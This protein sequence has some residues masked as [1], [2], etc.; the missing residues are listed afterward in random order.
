MKKWKIGF[1]A[2]IFLLLGSV[3]V[4]IPNII[5]L[6][7]SIAIK[8]ARPA[9]FRTLPDK[10]QLI[11]WWPGEIN[12]DSIH[13]NN[14]YYRINS[15]NLSLLTIS[16]KGENADMAS[17]LVLIEILNDSTQMEWIGSM[18][19]SYNP[20]KRVN[21]YLKAKQIGRDMNTILQKMKP[22]F[23][24]TKNIYGFEIKEELVADSL[25]IATSASCKGFPTTQFIYSLIDKLSNYA[26]TNSSME[27]GYPMLNVTTADSIFFDV[28]VAIPT[29]KLLPG[30]GDI[31]QKRML[32]RGNILVTEVKG[33][34]GITMNA[35]EQIQRYA[36]DYQRETPAIPFFSLITDRRKEPDSGKWV[37][38]IYLPVR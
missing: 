9:I 1:L 20:V 28:K 35:F 2:G 15:G 21:A 24:D 33:G 26:A 10:K 25:L 16:I 13:F 12:N 6:T 18:A 34:I 22:F 4:F 30:S 32:G 19:T 17:S 7:S 8:A 31:K 27:S 37:T 5:K 29:N 11:K 14:F 23:R 38:K 3:Y 36:D